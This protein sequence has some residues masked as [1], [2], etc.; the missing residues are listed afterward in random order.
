[1]NKIT[2]FLWFDTQA[3][4]AAEFYV[5]IFKDAKILEVT[6]YG[7]AG[8][9][10]KGQVMTVHFQLE[11]QTFA[12][13]NGGPEFT[14]NEAISLAVNVETQEELDE[15][16]QKLSVGGDEGNCGWLKDKYGVSWQIVPSRLRDLLDDN[17]PEKTARVMKAL[18]QMQKI[19]IATLERAAGA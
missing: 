14:F 10:P 15:L 13:L 9:R 19:D 18:L 4:E 5:S 1:M 17:S 11:G 12:A 3:Q 7:E 16:W 8:P 6:H 2:P